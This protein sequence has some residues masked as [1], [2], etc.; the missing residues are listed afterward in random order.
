MVAP[1]WDCGVA[2]HVR[3][4]GGVSAAYLE[5]VFGVDFVHTRGH[6]PRDKFLAKLFFTVSN[7]H[8]I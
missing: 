8:P 7:S 6:W 2:I 5:S 4:G 1:L 3:D